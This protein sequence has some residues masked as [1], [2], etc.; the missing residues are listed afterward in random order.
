M[1]PFYLTVEVS[2][3][4]NRLT[5]PPARNIRLPPKARAH[6]FVDGNKR[7]AAAVAEMFLEVNG[8]RLDLT[9]EQ[10]VELFLSIAARRLSRD[11]VDEVFRTRVR[12]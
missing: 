11:D 9:N 6:A 3:L 10:I 1:R 4:L 8:A 5:L 2:V 12:I 7:I